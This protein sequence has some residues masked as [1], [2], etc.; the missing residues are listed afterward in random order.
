LVYLGYSAYPPKDFDEAAY[1]ALSEDEQ[2]A[3]YQADV[4]RVLDELVF[5]VLHKH[6]MWVEWNRNQATRIRLTGA[7]WYAQLA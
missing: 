2:R 7:R 5:P 1:D 4:E 3:R 6:G